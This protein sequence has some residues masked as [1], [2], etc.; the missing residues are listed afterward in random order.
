MLWDL[1]TRSTSIIGD[2]PEEYRRV[3]MASMWTLVL[4]GAAAYAT[5][6]VRARPLLLGSVLLGVVLLFVGRNGMR[7]VLHRGLKS[8]DP[9]HRVFIVAAESQ[10]EVLGDQ[11]RKSRGIFGEVGTWPLDEDSDPDPLVV[12]KAA[13]EA[14]AD[15]LLYSPA[16][17]SDP[18]WPRRLGWAMEDTELSLLVSPAIAE[19]AGPRLA[20]EPVQGLALVRVEIPR[21]SGPART[22][23]RAIDAVGAALA[24]ALFAVP[25][26]VMAATI[27]LTSNGPVFFRQ[28]RAGAGGSTFGCWKFRTMY[29]GADSQRAVLRAESG[30][31]GATFKMARDPRVTGVGRFL[32]RFSLDEL[33]QLFNVLVGEMSLV[34][35]RP[36]PLDDVE[37]YD[38]VA[39]RRLLAKPGMTGLW[40]VSGRSDLAWR[41]AVMLDLYYVENWS[42]SLDLIIMLRTAKAVLA[43]RGAY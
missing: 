8:G 36:H 27:K 30:S 16:D 5:G 39:T 33:P 25:M 9:L 12:V 23:K 22:V 15:T 13:R 41:D 6:T 2:G 31:A 42:I 4:T 38:D 11:L 35:P 32:R 1:E 34:G 10:A 21:F 24:L 43:G 7:I 28:E 26:L 37:L 14:A 3:L 17:H 29:T 40:Q 20:I 19:I 18:T